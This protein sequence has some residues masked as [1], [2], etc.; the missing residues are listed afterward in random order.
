MLLVWITMKNEMNLTQLEETLLNALID[1]LYA[2]E[3]FSDIEAN[4]LAKWTNTD[5]KIVRGVL[6][7]LI[8]K[9][10]VSIFQQ[11]GETQN[12]FYQIIYLNEQ[13]YNLHPVWGK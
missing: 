3:G 9:G 2:E 6:G 1:H 5:I 12:H 7:S 11:Q 8:K 13:Y 10:I 4:D